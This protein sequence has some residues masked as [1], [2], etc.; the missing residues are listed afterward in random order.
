MIKTKTKIIFSIL[1]IMTIIYIG[2]KVFDEQWAYYTQKPSGR[3]VAEKD[4]SGEVSEQKLYLLKDNNNEFNIYYMYIDRQSEKWRKQEVP[5][6]EIITTTIIVDN[7]EVD[8]KY[9]RYI[10][11]EK[12]NVYNLNLS[13]FKEEKDIDIFRYAYIGIIEDTNIET[14]KLKTNYGDV[15]ADYIEE[16]EDKTYFAIL[17]TND[18]SIR[19]LNTDNLIIEKNNK[20]EKDT[21]L[22]I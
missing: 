1:V 16:K 10:Y 7:Q 19:W 3:M 8:L 4:L 20:Y 9:K 14:I 2:S 11:D 21:S 12:H 5:Y 17:Y 6:D 13:N 15:E 22:E 18:M